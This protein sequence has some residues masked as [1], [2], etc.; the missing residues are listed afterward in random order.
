MIFDSPCFDEHQRVVFCADEASGLKAIIAVHSTAL[1]PAAGGCRMWPYKSEQEALTD[2]LRLAKGMSYK[3]AMADL[4]LGGG[5][6]V[7]IGDAKTDKTPERLRAFGRA[8][9]NLCGLYTTA[10]DVGMT[11]EDMA[12]IATETQY[13][14]GLAKGRN[15]SG[16]PSEATALGVFVGIKASVAHHLGAPHISGRMVA[17]QGLGNV[18]WHLCELLHAAGA[19]LIVTDINKSRIHD[20]VAHF[21]ATGVAPEAIYDAETDVFA[22]CALGSI[23]NEDTMSRLKVGVIAGSANNQLA[24]GQIGYDLAARGILYAPDYVINAGGVIN[25]SGEILG[26]YDPAAARRKVMTIGETLTDIYRSSEKWRVPPHEAADRMAKA[27]L[28]QGRAQTAKLLQPTA[29]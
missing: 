24:D 15:A 19:K 13:V 14:A 17:V 2:V 20:A 12:I 29:A 4:P 10:E 9:Q 18:G 5:K 8:V 23:L 21:G 3:N 11:P 25:A 27:K 26:S 7:I 1:G 6:A 16:D 22:P 28:R